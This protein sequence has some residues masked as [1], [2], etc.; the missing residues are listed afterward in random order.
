MMDNLVNFKFSSQV[1][2]N[3][4]PVFQVV[5]TI[6]PCPSVAV[7]FGGFVLHSTSLL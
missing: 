4:N 6:N 2:F 3:D 1:L 7:F 5:F